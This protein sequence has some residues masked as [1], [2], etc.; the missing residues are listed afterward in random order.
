MSTFCGRASEERSSG[1]P[2]GSMPAVRV[3]DA[4]SA[5]GGKLAFD[6]LLVAPLNIASHTGVDITPGAVV[7]TSRGGASMVHHVL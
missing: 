1:T 6:S 7:L 3:T 5:R 4:G 2:S